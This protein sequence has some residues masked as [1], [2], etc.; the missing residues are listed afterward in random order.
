MLREPA[1]KSVE[2][3]VEGRHGAVRLG[4]HAHETSLD[5]RFNALTED[6]RTRYDPIGV[7]RCGGDDPGITPGRAFGSNMKA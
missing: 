2:R 4:P 1:T 3:S 5:Y 7:S 6:Y